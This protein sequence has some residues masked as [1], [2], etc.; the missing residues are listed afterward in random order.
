VSGL[1]TLEDLL[2]E[3]VGEIEDEYD[4]AEPEIADL[5]DGVFRVDGKVGIDEVNEL[6]DVELPDEEWDTVAGLMLGLTGA[7]PKEGEEVAFQNLVFKAERVDGRRIAKV[8]ISRRE[9][10]PEDEHHAEATAE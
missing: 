10:E 6:L 7:I 4:R 1:V 8:L 2:E 5:G 3:L 9:P